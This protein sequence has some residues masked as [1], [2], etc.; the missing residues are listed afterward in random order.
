M[1][2]L[3]KL[4]RGAMSQAAIAK[5]YGVSQSTW[6]SWESGRTLP[7]LKIMLC[8]E[9]DFNIPLEVIFFKESNYKM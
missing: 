9:R 5:K 7:N 8:I 2:N 3:L 4:L 6:C 1:N